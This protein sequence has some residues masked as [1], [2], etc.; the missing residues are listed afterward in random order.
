MS[1]ASRPTSKDVARA[2]GVSQAAVS[3]VL[4][5]KWPGRVSAATAERVREAARSLGYRPNLAARDLRTGRTRTALLVVPALT[6]EFFAR[7]H[8][9]AASVA[10]AHGFGVL[11]YPSPEGTGPATDP[12]ASA[13]A[14]LDGVLASSMA[15]QALSG[16]GAGALPLVMLDSDPATGPGTATVNLA[17]ADGMRQA[18]GHLLELGH[19]D[20]VHLAA[21]VDSWTFEIRAAALAAS[22]AGV[23]GARLR[24]HRCALGVAEAQAAV[25]ALLTAPG[26]RPTA[27][28]CDDDLLAAGACKAARRLGVRVPGELSVTGFDD[29]TLAT[30]VEPELTTV[31]LP[32]EEFGARGMAALLTAVDG[33]TPADE[34]LPVTLTVRGSTGPAPAR[35]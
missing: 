29:L 31:T 1:A 10:A 17:I 25:T 34:E 12:F 3:L 16:I 11:L 13:P 7:V 18:A 27:L 8:A 22:V 20:L 32:A 33:G 5:G 30:A 4:G 23:P 28:V 21:D 19:R 35:T 15:A 9:G 2:A 6:N 24:T 26:E 14:A